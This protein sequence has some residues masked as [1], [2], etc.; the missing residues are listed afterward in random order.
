LHYINGHVDSSYPL[1]DGLCWGARANYM[2]L[3]GYQSDGIT[4][5]GPRPLN[6]NNS[7]FYGFHASGANFG[8][9]DGSVRYIQQGI[10]ISVFS[11]ML[12][13]SAGEIIPSDY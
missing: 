2:Q 8:F 9:G 12:T 13:A 4:S 10:P 6:A 7:E 3:E 5:P 1:S 11:A